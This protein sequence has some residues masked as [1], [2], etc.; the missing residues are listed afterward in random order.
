MDIAKIVPGIKKNVPLKNHTTF[1]VGGPAK[2]FFVAKNKKELIKI[3]DAA[4]KSKLPFFILGAG[5]NILVSDK[6]YNGIV[7][8]I[9]N[10][11]KK[12]FL[13]SESKIQSSNIYTGAGT[14]LAR[15]VKLSLDKSLSGLEW[16][17]G[18]PGTVG[19]AIYGN[20]GWPGDK[21]NISSIVKSVKVLF[22][23]PKMK[24]KDF[25]KKDCQFGYRES[26]F[27]H[28]KNLI[29]L[30]AIL[31]LKKGKRN[32]IK[33]EIIKI[34]KAK[35]NKIPAGFSAGC[36]FKN[37]PGLNAGELIEKSG[38]KGKKIGGAKI[39][40]KHANFIMNTKKAKAEDI[41]E[42]IK[43]VK[44]R[45]KKEFDVKLAEEIQIIK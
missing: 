1:R 6:G 26:I 31:Q 19:G 45:V 37:P 7:I 44:A 8:K 11:K 34:L 20:A 25:K 41:L 3:I 22:A 42:L 30:E 40:E 36:I 23:G 4:R 16:A 14:Q 12:K 18:I 10:S 13:A 39:S 2:Y 27:K 24:I 38:L 35:R 15:L 9:K 17:A 32:K 33:K 21:K 28:N 5:S 43:I 29:I